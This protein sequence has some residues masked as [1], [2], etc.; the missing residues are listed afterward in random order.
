[1]ETLKPNK[2]LRQNMSVKKALPKIILSLILFACAN[3]EKLVDS[4]GNVDWNRYYSTQE[5]YEIMREYARMYPDLTKIY[6][7]GKSYKGAELLMMEI[8]NKNNRSAEDKPGFYVDGNIHSGELTGSAVTLYLMGYLL[9]NYGKNTEIT[10]LVDTRTFYLRPKFNPDGSDLALFEGVSLR[11]SVRPVDNDGDGLKDEDPAED[12]NGDGYMTR[13]RFKDPEGMWKISE[14]DQRIMVRRRRNETGEEYYSVMGEGIDNDKDGRTNED[15]IGGLDLNRNFPRNWELQY[16]QPGAGPFPLSEPETYN[17]VKFIDSHPNITGIVHNHTSGGFVYRLP[18]TANPNTFPPAD[19]DLIKLLGQEY[20][21]MTGRPVE[22]SYTTPERHR[23]GTLI[24]W[25]YWD[26]GIIGWVPEY[27][28]G[29]KADYNSDGNTTEAERLR[30]DDENLGG[31]YFVDWVKWDHPEYG[32]VE[33][34]GWRRM[35]VTQNPP[36]ELLEEECRIQMPWILYLAKSSPLIKIGE[37]EITE[38]ETGVFRI[39]AEITNRGFLPTNLTDR[40]IEAEL[41]KPVY[42]EIELTG[43]EV[44]EPEKKITAGHLTGSW[45]H[46]E[47]SSVS[48]VKVEWMVRKNA[49]SAFVVIRAVSEK[50]GKVETKEIEIK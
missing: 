11:S 18:S 24:S 9:N 34:G 22:R 12:L 43:A 16:L 13:M 26:K 8:T 17:T 10:D 39:E 25:G 27:W 2:Q 41:I 23:Y 31:E 44:M 48:S 35:F 5:T 47:K 7:I 29:F 20:T 45:N 46:P 21:N 1:M 15:G 38:T 50:G 40:A 19:I 3:Q 42:A 28:S 4:D 33:I 37:P 6:S 36:P 14:D 30:Y 49:S 32:E